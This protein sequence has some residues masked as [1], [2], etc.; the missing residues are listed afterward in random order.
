VT[1]IIK[2]ETVFVDRIEFRL[3][4]RGMVRE[5]G[6]TSVCEIVGVELLIFD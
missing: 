6:M 2:H 1:D 5:Q 4:F 3:I